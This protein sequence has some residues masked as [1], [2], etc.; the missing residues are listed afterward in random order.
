MY[1]HIVVVAVAEANLVSMDKCFVVELSIACK[2][3][4]TK[5]INFG[6]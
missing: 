1:I 3:L 6:L 4:G 5:D 2:H